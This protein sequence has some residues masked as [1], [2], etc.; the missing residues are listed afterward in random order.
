MFKFHGLL[1]LAIVVS[2]VYSKVP[3]FIVFAGVCIFK[4]QI[5]TLMV[6][7]YFRFHHLLELGIVLSWVY[8]NVSPFIVF[9][10]A[11]VV[12]GNIA[13]LVPVIMRLCPLTR[14]QLVIAAWICAIIALA[15][16][17]GCDAAILYWLSHQ[18]GTVSMTTERKYVYACV[19]VRYFISY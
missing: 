5:N 15:P 1:E 10:G 16:V 3:E 2:W 9:A 12:L 7:S 19:Y 13:F 11:Q 14:K 18:W 17:I 6:L 4:H 8:S